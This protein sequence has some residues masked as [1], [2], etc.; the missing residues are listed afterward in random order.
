MNHKLWLITFYSM[1]MISNVYFR[2]LPAKESAR[3]TWSKSSKSDTR[4]VRTNGS[5]R[6]SDSKSSVYH[7]LSWV[8]T[9]T[10]IKSWKKLHIF[11][12]FH[13]ACFEDNGSSF[14]VSFGFEFGSIVSVSFTN[15]RLWLV[16]ATRLDWMKNAQGNF[17]AEKRW[18][19]WLKITRC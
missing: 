3:P 4:P 2:M 8:F 11:G 1:M 19:Y 12:S 5:S 6:N 7:T 14:W 10:E 18:S 16:S 15:K 9:T 13:C 17:C